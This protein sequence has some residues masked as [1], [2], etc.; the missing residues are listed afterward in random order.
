M[1]HFVKQGDVFKSTTFFDKEPYIFARMNLNH[2]C[3]VSLS[4]NRYTDDNLAECLQQP[5]DVLNRATVE[6][7]EYVGRFD[8]E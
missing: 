4:G 6:T 5:I 8:S 3:L 7:W 1:T 2:L